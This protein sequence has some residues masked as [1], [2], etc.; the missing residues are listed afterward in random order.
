M[1]GIGRV[2]NAVHI[3]YS[4]VVLVCGDVSIYCELG[5][6]K[7]VGAVLSQR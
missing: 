4:D 1:D 5:L 7:S 2:P 6:W 3:C